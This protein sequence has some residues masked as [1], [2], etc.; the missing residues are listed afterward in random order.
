MYAAGWSINDIVAHHKTSVFRVRT[1]LKNAGVDTSV[2]RRAS[3]PLRACVLQMVAAGAS[4][5]KV[6]NTIDISSHLIRQVMRDEKTNVAG[7][8]NKNADVNF[9]LTIDMTKWP[10]FLE[11]YRSG[12]HG[13]LLCADMCEFSDTDRVEAVF[14]LKEEDVQAH[15]RALTSRIYK[16]RNSGLSAATVGKKFGVSAALVKGIFASGGTGIG[17]RVSMQ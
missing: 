1:I 12:T 8:R 11:L 3:E 6:S 17:R 9:P 2:Y 5:K 13:F 14:R 7:L 10:Q 16:Q 4:V 15:H